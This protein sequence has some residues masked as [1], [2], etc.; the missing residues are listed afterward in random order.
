MKQLYDVLLGVDHAARDTGERIRLRVRESDPLSAAI[1]AEELADREFRD[2]GI[3]YTHAMRVRPVPRT[4][5]ASAAAKI[6]LPSSL[7]L[8]LA[9]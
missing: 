4:P 5:P 3:S 6:P 9:A 7:T 2:N 8:P 1:T